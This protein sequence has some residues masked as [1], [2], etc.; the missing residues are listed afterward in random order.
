[1]V[2]AYFAANWAPTLDEACGDGRRITEVWQLPSANPVVRVRIEGD[3]GR[4]VATFSFREDGRP[5]GYHVTDTL[6][7]G[8]YNIVIATSLDGYQTTADFYAALLGWKVVRHD[9]LKI[10]P[11]RASTLQ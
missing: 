2:V 5:S 9:W 3:A 8:I 11:S 6:R 4:A 7:E 1:M 10:A